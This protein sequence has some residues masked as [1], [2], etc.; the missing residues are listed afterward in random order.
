MGQ[1]ILL[2]V[3][4]RI[5]AHQIAEFEQVFSTSILPLIREHGLRF[6]GIW[7]CLV[8]DAG[9][10]LELWEFSSLSDF[11][12]QWRNLMRDPR[13]QEI[14]QLTGPMVEGERFTLFE[15]ALQSDQHDGR[16]REHFSV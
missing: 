14:F 7:K 13:L 1:P 8:G 15:P 6:L 3:S 4:Y 10:F 2:K 11:E 12:T 16:A 9:E 5:R